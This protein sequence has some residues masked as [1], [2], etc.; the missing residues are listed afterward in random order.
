MVQPV[1]LDEAPKLLTA[2]PATLL[3]GGFPPGALVM[4][5]A[6]NRDSV[7]AAPAFT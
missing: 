4:Q 3:Q 5:P 2:T 7:K 1:R 6:L